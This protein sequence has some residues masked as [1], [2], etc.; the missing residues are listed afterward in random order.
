MTRNAKPCS[1]K[2]VR[3]GFTLIELLVVIAIIAMLAALLLPAVQQAREAGR[4]AQ[5]INNVKQIVLA[6]N[7][8][9]SSYRCFPPGYITPAP[10]AGQQ[11]PSPEPAQLN[12]RIQ[13]QPTI[14]TVQNWLMPAEWGWQSFILSQMGQGTIDIDYR[15][16]KFGTNNQQ[17]I[18]TK[19]ESYIC[20]SA[21]LPNSRPSNWGY[22][23]YRGSMGAYD[24]NGSGPPNAPQTPNGMLYQGSAV[25]MADVTDGASNTILVG[26]SLYGFWGDAYSCCVR[27][28]DDSTHPD[29]F[30]TYWQ[31]NAASNVTLQFFSF[32]STHGGDQAIF[33]LVDGSARQVSKK[34]D[35]NVL[36]AVATRNGALKS[37]SPMM[38]NVMDGF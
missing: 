31:V 36:K 11:A 17:F 20:P 22:A 28:W 18:E 24:T 30:D 14:T 29:L 23:T 38:E 8:Y 12:T 4:R 1:S 27:V 10:G 13:R 35:S 9:E 26:D 34:I 19:I 6:M 16:P 25:R 2:A 33:G 7:N 15:V 37:I 5:C 21:S 32:G 3:R